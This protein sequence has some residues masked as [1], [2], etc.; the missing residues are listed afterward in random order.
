MECVSSCLTSN[1]PNHTIDNYI[2][3]AFAVVKN[4]T[5]TKVQK[6][7][8]IELDRENAGLQAIPC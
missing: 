8:I 1:D 5:D 2:L 4:I 7:L 3:F 6:T